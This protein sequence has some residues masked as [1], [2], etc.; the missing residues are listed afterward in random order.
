MVAPADETRRVGE[1]RRDTGQGARDRQDGGLRHIGRGMRPPDIPPGL[2]AEA[3]R[4]DM[5]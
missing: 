3:G 4:R 5:G 1:G 2:N